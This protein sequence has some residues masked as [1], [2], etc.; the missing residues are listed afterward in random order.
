[1]CSDLL[2]R[3]NFKSTKY[4]SQHHFYPDAATECL[5]PE[6]PGSHSK[7]SPPVLWSL[8]IKGKN[9]PPAPFVPYIDSLHPRGQVSIFNTL[10]MRSIQSSAANLTNAS[11]NYF[12]YFCSS[13]FGGWSIKYWKKSYVYHVKLQLKQNILNALTFIQLISCIQHNDVV[14]I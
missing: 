11:R 9:F 14:I 4:R 6:F 12:F 1:V 2:E 10:E 5:A 7:L 8:T 13:I 3:Q